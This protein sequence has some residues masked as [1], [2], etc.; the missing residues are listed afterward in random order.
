MT[1]K[2][3]RDFFTEKLGR[4]FDPD[5]SHANGTIRFDV[6]GVGCWRLTAEKGQLNLEESR[7][8]SEC[9]VHLK[10]SDLHDILYGRS[11]LF[12]A[13]LRGR[14]QVEG[15]RALAAKCVRYLHPARE[16]KAA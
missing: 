1:Q 2:N 16:G 12:T 8:P 3:V 11:K 13:F 7:K 15:N 9:T 5:F 6:E 14:V 10:E 4:S